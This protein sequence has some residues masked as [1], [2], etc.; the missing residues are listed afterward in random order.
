M[1]W[2]LAVWCVSVVLFLALLTQRYW[3][4]RLPFWLRNMRDSPLRWYLFGYPLAV[5]RIR[6]TW[7][8]LCQNTDLSVMR[9]S[10]YTAVNRDTM[11]RGTPIRPTP[12]RLGLIRPTRNGFTLRVHL[13]PGQ[14]PA[15]FLGN[16]EA[17]VHAWRIH[18]VRIVSTKRG[19]VSMIAT[20]RDP[21]ADSAAAWS[22]FPA[23]RLMAAIVGRLADGAAW[24]MDFRAVPH[25]L[26]TGATQSGKSTLLAAL[27]TALGAQPVAIVGIDLKGGMEL[28][29]FE[30]RLSGL[31]TSRTEAIALLR[32]VIDDLGRRMDTC[33]ADGVRS[34]WELDEDD[35]PV[36]VVIVV[37]EVAELYLAADSAGKKEAAECSTL[38][39]RTAQLGAALG[40]HLVISAQRFGSDLGPGATALRAQLGG[41]ICHRVTDETT[42]EMTLGDLF[43]DAVIVAQAIGEHE[44]GVAVTTI[45]GQWTRARSTLVTPDQAR[46]HSAATS[47]HMPTLGGWNE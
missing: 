29:L 19:E 5:C 36:P 33:R 45:G 30:K 43:P 20:H 7:R 1:P 9:R 15:Q 42:A 11:V 8:R 46:Q 28:G 2:E 14:T 12:P 37:D 47:H 10:R 16:A 40:V 32:K 27:V 18:E 13:H 38:L 34:I 44:K 24:V 23:A 41:R 39:L 25:W 21:L 17:F 6:F 26:I 4:S 31:A 3:E 35:R 22:T